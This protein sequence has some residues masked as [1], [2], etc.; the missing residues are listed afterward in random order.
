MGRSSAISWGLWSLWLPALTLC[1][2]ITI[3]IWKTSSSHHHR[4]RC[5]SCCAVSAFLDC[6]LQKPC[7]VKPFSFFPVKYL[8]TETRKVILCG[9]D[10]N[11]AWCLDLF[12]VYDVCFACMYVCT[13][14]AYLVPM[15]VRRGHQIYWN[16]NYRWLWA[17]I[18]RYWKSSLGP[19][20]EQ[21]VF[22]TAELSLQPHSV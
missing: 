18:Y 1:F 7:R 4:P 20:Q 16:W 5:F 14:W 2:F 3:V 21:W 6:H 15:E 22:L 17:T 10:G 9:K 13:P 19:L 11:M 12:Y 8:I